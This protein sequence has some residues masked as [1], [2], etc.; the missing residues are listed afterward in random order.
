MQCVVITYDVRDEDKSAAKQRRQD[1]R[2]FIK[3]Q[4]PDHNVRLSE[5]T[6]AIAIDRP[7]AAL[8]EAFGELIDKKTDVL[9]VLFVKNADGYAL[10]KLKRRLK[11][12]LQ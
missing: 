4:W 7:L 10:P 1:I 11:A 9:F 12:L 6:Y 3:E 2:D 5:S 8:K